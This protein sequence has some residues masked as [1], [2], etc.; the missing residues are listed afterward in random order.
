MQ[1]D[2]KSVIDYFERDYF[3][4]DYFEQTPVQTRC[5]FGAVLPQNQ[6]PIGTTA[7]LGRNEDMSM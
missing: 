1:K 3:E 4:C 2:L 6:S 7:H 5:G